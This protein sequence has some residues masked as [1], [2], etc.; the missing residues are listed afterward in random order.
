M[1]AVRG[2]SQLAVCAVGSIPAPSLQRAGDTSQAKL[3]VILWQ[4]VNT[5]GSVCQINLGKILCISLGA[6]CSC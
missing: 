6:C 5:G 2:G 4:I 3:H 1:A